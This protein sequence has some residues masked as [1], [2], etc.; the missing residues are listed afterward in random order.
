MA[1][2]RAGGDGDDILDALYAAP[3]RAFVAERKRVVAALKAA[4]RDEEARAIA[5]MKRPSASVWAVNQLARRAPGDA[6]GALEL[7]ATLRARSESCCAAATRTNS[8]TEAR[9]ARHKVAS[10]A[11]R[12]EAIVGRSG[13]E[14][15]VTLG[16]KI[17]QTLQAASIGDDETRAQLRA[18]RLHDDLAAP[19]TFGTAGDLATTLAASIGATSSAKPGARP[20]GRARARVR[21]KRRRFGAAR[22]GCRAQERGCRAQ[23]RRRGAQ[24]R[25]RRAQDRRRR[26]QA[27]RRRAQARRRRVA[28]SASRPGRRAQ[29]RRHARARGRRRRSRRHRA[30]A[31]RRAARAAVERAESQLRAAKDAL[32]AAE[33]AAAAARRAADEAAAAAR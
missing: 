20:Q 25:R 3:P 15:D 6:R 13:A 2:K 27:R 30:H 21:A 1:K 32:A 8:W 33:L 12:A 31:R 5:R 23:E 11:R 26:A 19:S 4:G 24:D 17:A 29:A 9:T 16:R 7:G 18:G 10:L 14:A 22:R 28:R